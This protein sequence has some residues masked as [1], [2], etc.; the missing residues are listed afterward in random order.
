ML[1]ARGE[2]LHEELVELDGRDDA[3]HVGEV[4]IQR[5]LR[6]AGDDLAG[7]GLVD[8]SAEVLDQGDISRIAARGLLEFDL[9]VEIEAIQHGGVGL[10]D[11]KRPRAGPRGVDG[12]ERFPEELGEVLAVRDRRDVVGVRR[13]ASPDTSDGEEHLLPL[14]L[15]VLDVGLDQGA[16]R[17][18]TRLD[19]VLL[20]DIGGTVGR[21]VGRRIVGRGIHLG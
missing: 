1:H 11:I 9:D 20:E 4:G 14:G 19:T 3:V 21:E 7:A 5:A 2:S 12:T 8:S 18:E 17:E 10:V 15:A 16:R 6:G 13:V